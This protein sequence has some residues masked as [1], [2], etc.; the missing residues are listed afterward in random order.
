LLFKF[1]LHRYTE[2]LVDAD[3]QWSVWKNPVPGSLTSP[4]AAVAAAELDFFHAKAGGAGV[5]AEGEDVDALEG[6]DDDEA[7]GDMDE[8][9][10]YVE[11][12]RRRQA[13][14][15]AA[16]AAKRGAGEAAI[17]GIAAVPT[18]QPPFQVGSVPSAAAAEK[19]AAYA[20]GAAPGPSRRFLC[21]NMLGTVVST[22]EAGSDFNSVGAVE[23]VRI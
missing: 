17:A 19:D 22:G 5:A 10:Y 18:P 16:A 11:M 6:E 1:N 15:K 8:E 2:A 3:G 14:R 20:A 21:Y 7:L 23:L 13:K 4:T 9:E 12:E